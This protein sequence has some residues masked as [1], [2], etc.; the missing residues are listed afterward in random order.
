MLLGKRN[1]VRLSWAY[2]D[3]A[4]NVS[5]KLPFSLGRQ[6]RSGRSHLQHTLTNP[7]VSH[8]CQWSYCYDA[9]LKQKQPA[10]WNVGDL[11]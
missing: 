1:N 7:L 8:L 3:A 9:P 11:L 4:L 2:S 6:T 5:C 10:V